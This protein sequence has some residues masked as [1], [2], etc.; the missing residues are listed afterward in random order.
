MSDSSSKWVN[1]MVRPGKKRF[2]SKEIVVLYFFHIT[3]SVLHGSI[4]DLANV[5]SNKHII[6]DL[7]CDK[8]Q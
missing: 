5:L 3:K 1:L 7:H 4:L 8:F 2:L 6:V